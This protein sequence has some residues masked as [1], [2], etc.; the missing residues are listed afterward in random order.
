MIYHT[1]VVSAILAVVAAGRSLRSG[2][3]TSSSNSYSMLSLQMQYGPTACKSNC[4]N[5]TDEFFTLHGLW[6]D[7]AGENA[8]PSFC[9]D[10]K[11]DENE[12]ANLLDQMNKYWPSYAGENSGFWAH[13]YE[14]HGTCAEDIL[15][16]EHDFFAA[17]LG[18]LHQYQPMDILHNANIYPSDQSYAK[19][20]IVGAL[21]SK[22]GGY[23]QIGCSGSNVA[24]F[25]IC[26]DKKFNVVDC[27]TESG[28]CPDNVYMRPASN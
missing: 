26:F 16:T 23:V 18:L 1:L 6:P 10:Q 3:E 28:S 11:F 24:G 20:D 12:I 5:V 27:P 17:A 15:A 2:A 19:S 13:E 21:H 22:I 25:G 9:T 4:D 8:G 14:K 7:Y